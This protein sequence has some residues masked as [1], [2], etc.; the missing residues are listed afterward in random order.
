MY[1][2]I[3]DLWDNKRSDGVYPGH[4][5]RLHEVAETAD[6]GYKQRKKITVKYFDTE[7]L[8][9]KRT[10]MFN[11]VSLAKDTSYKGLW[12]VSFILREF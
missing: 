8:E 4:V 9:A 5:C 2:W 11:K 6:G 7:T 10:E 1:W 3:I 12:K